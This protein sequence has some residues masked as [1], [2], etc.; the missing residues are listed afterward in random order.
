MVKAAGN[1]RMVCLC[2][3]KPGYEGKRVYV[4]HYDRNGFKS[5]SLQSL[6]TSFSIQ[7][8]F[9]NC[10]L[11]PWFYICNYFIKGPHSELYRLVSI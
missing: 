3:E 4:N 9:A 10:S 8:I 2:E 5:L 7:D 1:Y 11:C 6:V